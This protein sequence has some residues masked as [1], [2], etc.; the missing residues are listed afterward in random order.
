[1]RLVRIVFALVLVLAACGDDG[2]SGTPLIPGGGGDTSTTTAGGGTSATTAGTT[3]T[4]TAPLT[5]DAMIAELMTRCE[6]GEFEMCDILYQA[7]DFDSIEE[8]FADSCGGRVEASGETCSREFGLTI[9]LGAWQAACGEGDM[10]ACDLLYI[11]SDFDSVE[12]AYA[13]SCGGVGEGFNRTCTVSYGFTY[14]G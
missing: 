5:G 14:T 1:M 12:E 6:A 9:D 11:F 4:T 7:S 8:A 13:D 10:V 3:A 2:G